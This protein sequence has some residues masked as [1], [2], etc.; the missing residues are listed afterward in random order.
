MG[1]HLRW[2]S[3]SAVGP[4]FDSHIEQVLCEPEII[5]PDLGWFPRRFEASTATEVQT[6]FGYEQFQFGAF[7]NDLYSVS[8]NVQNFRLTRN[9]LRVLADGNGERR[10]WSV[11]KAIVIQSRHCGLCAVLVPAAVIRHG[12]GIALC[13]RYGLCDGWEEK[14]D[15]AGR[16][17]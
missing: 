13:S 2:A 14:A 9:G 8:R 3:F 10:Q 1:F 7:R 5:V 16:F 4:G 11:S 17:N 6:L 15:V 12:G